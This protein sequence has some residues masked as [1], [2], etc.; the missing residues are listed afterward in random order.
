MEGQWRQGLLRGERFGGEKEKDSLV[1]WLGFF[2][3]YLLLYQMESV[4]EWGW[5]REKGG[6]CGV[7]VRGGVRMKPPCAR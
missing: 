6:G 1:L 5:G 7:D 3:C 2:C 4:G